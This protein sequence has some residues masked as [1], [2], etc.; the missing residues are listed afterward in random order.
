MAAVLAAA[1]L[2]LEPRDDQHPVT[3]ACPLGLQVDRGDVGVEVPRVDEGATVPGSLLRI[4]RVVASER[5]VGHAEDVEARSTVEIDGSRRE[6]VPSLQVEWAWSSQRSARRRTRALMPP[7]WPRPPLWWETGWCAGSRTAYEIPKSRVRRLEPEVWRP[8]PPAAH[9]ENA[10]AGRNSATNWASVHHQRVVL[11]NAIPV[12]TRLRRLM[13]SRAC[14]ALWPSPGCLAWMQG[15]EQ[16]AVDQASTTNRVRRRL[17]A[18]LA[19]RR[20]RLG[21]TADADSCE[22]LAARHRAR[23]P[24][25]RLKAPRSS[26]T[27]R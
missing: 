6:S 11:A 17:R 13:R 22:R 19:R 27:V 21:G 26:R 7:V 9:A 24:E 18:T 2:E 12:S 3:D 10:R 16:L 15:P 20:E 5:V 4:P 25:R 8:S 14:L 23:P 1:R